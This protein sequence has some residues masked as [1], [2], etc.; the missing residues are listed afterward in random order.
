[1]Q[2]IYDR[3]LFENC[4]LAFGYGCLI[5]GIGCSGWLGFGVGFGFCVG[6]V[7]DALILVLLSKYFWYHIQ[8]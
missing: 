6:L 5:G 1:M 2:M 3:L 4:I 7:V 8:L